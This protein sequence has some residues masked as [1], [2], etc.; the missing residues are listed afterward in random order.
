M[1][2]FF[3]GEADVAWGCECVATVFAP[4]E[5]TGR[6]PVFSGSLPEFVKRA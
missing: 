3:N 5:K 1:L 4:T 2:F 6:P